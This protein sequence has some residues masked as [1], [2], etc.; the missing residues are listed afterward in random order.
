MLSLANPHPLSL[1]LY[2]RNRY[3]SPKIYLKE[4]YVRRRE[5]FMTNAIM[6]S[7]GIASGILFLLAGLNLIVG[8]PI[9]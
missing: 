2:R 9:L 4:S 1:I 6:I 8:H 3:Y 5:K 7:G